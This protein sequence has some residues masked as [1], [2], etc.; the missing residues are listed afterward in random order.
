[1]PSA[2]CRRWFR[3]RPERRKLRAL[4]DALE[5]DAHLDDRQ[6]AMIG[7]LR[8]LVP[9]TAAVNGAGRK[10]ARKASPPARGKFRAHGPPRPPDPRSWPRAR[11][12]P[13]GG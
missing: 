12:L 13:E 9:A 10:V 3:A 6:R 7:E 5:S 11:G 8:K 1:M 2:R 4:L